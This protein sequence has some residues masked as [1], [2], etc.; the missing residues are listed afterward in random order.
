MASGGSLAQEVAGGG[1]ETDAAATLFP[2]QADTIFLMKTHNRHI[3][4]ITMPGIAGF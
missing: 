1:E 4:Y 2:I 3:R